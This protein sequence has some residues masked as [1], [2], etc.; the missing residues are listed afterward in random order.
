MMVT[1]PP[2]SVFA[3]P[4]FDGAAAAAE[5]LAKTPGLADLFEP[6]NPGMHTTPTVDYAV[7]ISGSVVLEVDEG[8][9]VRLEPGDVVVQNGTRHAWRVPPSDE[10]ATIFVILMGAAG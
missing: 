1:F 2:D 7:V 5:N 6:D 4:S 8:A 10:P 3:D 9:A